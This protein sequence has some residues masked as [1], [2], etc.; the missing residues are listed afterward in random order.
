M[1]GFYVVLTE[2][3][4]VRICYKKLT[5]FGRLAGCICTKDKLLRNKFCIKH[6]LSNS[7]IQTSTT[8]R[9]MSIGRQTSL[10]ICALV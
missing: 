9:R 1:D 5:Q 8:G 3:M 2:N 4:L 10:C 7:A 6:R